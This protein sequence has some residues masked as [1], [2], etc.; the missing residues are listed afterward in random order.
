MYFVSVLSSAQIETK[1]QEITK[2]TG[3]LKLRDKV[4]TLL[5]SLYAI[6]IYIYIYIY[7]NVEVKSTLA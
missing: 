4:S 5:H 7:I 1:L 3:I 6:Y 2:Q